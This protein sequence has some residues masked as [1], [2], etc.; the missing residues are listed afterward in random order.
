VKE[1]VEEKIST[2]KSVKPTVDKRSRSASPERFKNG[3]PLGEIH[4]S[5][6]Y[7]WHSG[8]LTEEEFLLQAI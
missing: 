6:P 1:V 3:S 5:L 7:L 8:S 2:P 4:K